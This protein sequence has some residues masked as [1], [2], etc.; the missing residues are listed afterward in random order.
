ML[1][2]SHHAF[3][4]DLSCFARALAEIDAGDLA[5]VFAVREE[6]TKFRGALHGHHVMEDTTIFPDLRGKHP[7]LAS[8]LDTLGEHHRAI[9]PLLERGDLELAALTTD[10]AA[11]RSV[12]DELASP[13]P[14]HRCRP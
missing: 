8:A 6:W 4:R 1:L 7:Q 11:A 10:I 2:C 3:R 9:D 5:R 14:R 12:I 13:R